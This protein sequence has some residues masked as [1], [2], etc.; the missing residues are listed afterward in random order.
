ME[1]IGLASVQLIAFNGSISSMI[2][3]LLTVRRIE[4]IFLIQSLMRASY[5]SE[6]KQMLYIEHY[7]IKSSAWAS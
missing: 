6:M 1:E 7:E 2:G 4:N 5:P 3:I